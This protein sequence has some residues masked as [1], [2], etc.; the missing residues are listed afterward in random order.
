M[1][2]LFFYVAVRLKDPNLTKH[3]IGSKTETKALLKLKRS[4]KG[5]LI[6]QILKK[7][8][9]WFHKFIKRSYYVAKNLPFCTATTIPGEFRACACERNKNRISDWNKVAEILEPID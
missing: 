9:F 4:L 3:F 1:I 6:A 7:L 8:K 5:L 2:Q